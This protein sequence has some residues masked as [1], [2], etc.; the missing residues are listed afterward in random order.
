MGTC[1]KRCEKSISLLM[2]K[3]EDDRVAGEA[4][5]KVV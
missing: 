1:K 2:I 5:V 4:K 3:G